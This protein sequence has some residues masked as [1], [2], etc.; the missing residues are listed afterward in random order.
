MDDYGAEETSSFEHIK[1]KRK[2][3]RWD[4]RDVIVPS[5]IMPVSITP[6]SQPKSEKRLK[7]S[8]PRPE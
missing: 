8:P 1:K 6:A 5:F 4:K 2:A 3:E 7:E